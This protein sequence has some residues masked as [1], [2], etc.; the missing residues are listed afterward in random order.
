MEGEKEK[1]RFFDRQ[2]KRD[3]VRLVTDSGRPMAQVARELGMG[4]DLLRRWRDQL[5][6][7]AATVAFPA[8]PSKSPDQLEIE[9]LKSR[10]AA[11]QSLFDYIEGFYNNG[12]L[13]SS[14]GYLTPMEKLTGI[15]HKAA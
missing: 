5:A 2:F 15:I 9:A 11:H 12:R 10:G 4:V 6:K 14:I 8:H 7:H 3:A 13:H 1:R